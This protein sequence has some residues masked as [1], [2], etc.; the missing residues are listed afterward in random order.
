MDCYLIPLAIPKGS[1]KPRPTTLR[2]SAA[3]LSSALERV[4]DLMLTKSQLQWAIE[5]FKSSKET[6]Q[7]LVETSQYCYAKYINMTIDTPMQ[8]LQ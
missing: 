2:L 1:W 7:T 5:A 4:V 3:C 6:S 8:W